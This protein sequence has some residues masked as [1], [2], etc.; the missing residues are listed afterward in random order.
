[1]HPSSHTRWC[2]RVVGFIAAC[3]SLFA[4]ARSFAVD[5]TWGSATTGGSWSVTTNWS[6][7]GAPTS[8]D[9]ALLG[10]A[11][12]NRTVFYNAAASGTL[13]GLSFTQTTTGVLNELQVQRAIRVT[14]AVTLGASSGTARLLLLGTAASIT[15]TF[16]GGVNVNSGGVLSLGL[17]NPAGG[18]T[19]YVPS[20]AS[21]VTVGGGL[22]ELAAGT[23]LGTG[24]AG[25]NHT[26]SGSLTMSSGTLFIDN[27]SNRDRRLTVTGNLSVTGGSVKS[28]A[29]STAANNILLSGAENTFT[30]QA[31]DFNTIAISLQLAGNQS[32]AGSTPLSVLTPRGTGIKT[33]SNSG[34]ISTLQFIDSG[35]TL[36]ARTTLKLASNIDVASAPIGATFSQTADSAGNVEFGIDA[37]LYTLDFSSAGGVWTPTKFSG[38]T[39]VTSGTA[40]NTIWHLTGT[41]G[42]IKSRGFNFATSGTTTLTT[43][44]GPGLV[45]VAT[46][47]TSTNVLSGSGTIDPTSTFRFA[48]TTTVSGTPAT[49]SS[50]RAIGNLEVTSGALRLGNTFTSL[51][52]VRVSGG[53]LDLLSKSLEVPS[54]QLT[55]GTI[56]TGTLTSSGTFDVQGGT[57]AAVILGSGSLTKTGSGTAVLSGPNGY[58]GTTSLAGGVLSLGVAESAGTSGPLGTNTAAGAIVLSGGT[59]QYTASNQFD[60]SS[61]FSTAAGQQYAAD[62]NGQAVTWGTALGSSGG[63]LTKSGF[64]TLTL[65]NANTYDGGTTI[66]GGTLAIGNGSTTGSVAGDITNNAVLAFNRSDSFAFGAVISGSGAVTKA[67]AGML[68]LTNANTYTGLTTVT[69]GTMVLGD[70]GTAGSVAGPIALASTAALVVNRSND[71]TL[72]E[73][74]SGTGSLTKQGVGTLSLTAANTFVGTTTISAGTISLSGGNNRLA[75]S[76][77]VNFGGNGGLSVSGSQSLSS[78]LLANNVAASLTGGAVTVTGI[79]FSVLATG[80]NTTQRLDASGLASFAYTNSGGGFK[81]GGA[82][83]TGT[84]TGQLILPASASITASSVGIGAELGG[85]S[86]LNSGTLT[87]GTT[88]TISAN[89]VSLGTNQSQGTM[90]YAGA[91]NPLLTI[92]ASNGT[93]ALPNMTIGTTAG[94]GLTLTSLVDLVGGVTGTS[95]LD[96]L[97]TNIV[98]GLNGRNSGG[99]TSAILTGG[100]V[101]GGGTLTSGTITLGR[102]TSAGGTVPPSGTPVTTGSLSVSGGTVN[103][104][105]LFLGDQNWNL[106]T[107]NAVFRL[108]GGGTLN[109]GTITTGTGAG[110]GTA[111]RTFQWSDGTIA[112]RD[113]GTDLSIGSGIA[114]TLASTGTHRFSI[115]SGRSGSVASV[116]S[117]AGGTLAKAGAG[118][119]TLSANNTYTGATTIAAGTLIVNG[120]QSAAVGAVTVDLG[121]TLAGSG[122][123]GGATTVN[124]TLSPGNSPGVLTLAELALGSTSTTLM[125]ITG[126]ARG[127][128]YDGLTITQPGGLGYGGTLSLSLTTT[129]TDNTT[130]DL[131]A[132]SGLMSG[133]FSSVT[134]TGSYGSLTFTNDGLGVWSSGPTTVAGQTMTF[135]QST[136]DLVI[137]PEPAGFVL[138][139]VGAS[140]VFWARRRR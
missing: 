92:R 71:L 36:G 91:V 54:V 80:S 5:Y 64:G 42:T 125:E 13:T 52:N 17:Y 34:T 6:P 97:V 3:C 110:S 12:A 38:T 50:D 133:S 84:A 100:L 47:G 75:T 96:A 58:S 57:L 40:T 70:G 105:T 77:T 108:D 93:G 132:F 1:M 30:P 8:A 138:L 28:N 44:I 2:R 122:T 59:L 79:Q 119:L 23:L 27:A 20:L 128:E 113:A 81:V 67:G 74:I 109:A 106:G 118:T 112:N 63:S 10:D 101:M 14:N 140:I 90:N 85:N 24:V 43:N 69:A 94:Y 86:F 41:A 127:G 22:F 21:N 65:T 26:I 35:T 99:T 7:N 55:G 66:T 39:G 53:S 82:N 137:V 126:T 87:L 78:L 18:S 107:V 15:G 111:V 33:V 120:N 102:T 136:G 104:D 19:V 31:Y 130:F 83:A 114:F 9:T 124:G 123:I 11:T 121:A 48:G 88:A 25:G 46:G 139:G 4:S 131:F 29:T 37:D 62:T 89:S 60:Y 95:T 76:G 134:A 98:V 49:L 16:S 117:G 56:T 45:L 103:V 116:L 68:T 32:F 51:Q 115:G 129:F 61:R 135:S 72:G 73:V